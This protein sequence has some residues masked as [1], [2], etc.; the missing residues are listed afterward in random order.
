MTK[1]DLYLR[2]PTGGITYKPKA[3]MYWGPTIDLVWVNRKGNDLM[4]ACLVDGNNTCNHHFYHQARLTVVS[5]K[6]DA[7]ATSGM[8]HPSQKNWHNF[9]QAKFIYELKNFPPTTSHLT[10]ITHI[11]NNVANL[12]TEIPTTL[13]TSSPDRSCLFKHKVWC[14]PTTMN[15]PLQVAVKARWSS[16]DHPTYE[17]GAI[18]SSAHNYLYISLRDRKLTSGVNTGLL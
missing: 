11:D 18:Y 1:W 17:N 5:L 3:G 16:N 6:Y 15:P 4:V 7:V 13:N 10:T 12:L 2:S 9:N 14:I 8:A